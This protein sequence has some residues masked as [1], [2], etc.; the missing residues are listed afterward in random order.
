MVILDALWEVSGSRRAR[1]KRRDWVRCEVRC[2][3]CGRL[4]GRL[5]GVAPVR[6]DGD[7]SA[8][9]PVAFVAFRP[10]DP[11]GPIVAYSPSLRFRCSACS[12]IGALDEIELFSTY[13]EVAPA[14]QAEAEEDE[15]VKRGRGRPVQPFEVKSRGTPLQV[16]LAEL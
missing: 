10:I 8:G 9:D 4:L 2:L 14:D 3:M 13:D 15:P 12:G 1:R 16:A 5:L 11:P 6:T 7:R